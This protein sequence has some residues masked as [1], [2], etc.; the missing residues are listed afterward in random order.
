MRAVLMLATV[1]L[2]APFPAAAQAPAVLHITVDVTDADQRSVPAARL[3]LLISDNP[4][5][6]TPRRV[7]T[8]TDGTVDVRL[9]PGNYTIESDQPYAFAGKAYEWVETLDVRGAPITLALTERNA[10]VAPLTDAVIAASKP[11][12]AALGPHLPAWKDSLVG[13]WTPRQRTSGFVID[14]R[15]LIATSQRAVGDA[16]T[17][18]VQVAPTLTVEGRVLVADATRD[19]AVLWIDSAVVSAMPPAPLG[20]GQPTLSLASDQDVVALGVP[21]RSQQDHIVR[22][23]VRRT[24]THTIDVDLRLPPGTPGGP[25]LTVD[26]TLIGITSIVDDTDARRRQARAVPIADACEVVSA[27]QQTMKDTPPPSAAHR[28]M[29]PATPFPIVALQDALA[30][31]AGNLNPYRT[32]ASDFDVAFITPIMVFAS[33]QP[34]RR[35]TSAD[36]RSAG[37]DQMRIPRWSDFG[38]WGDYVA[39]VRSVLLVRVTPRLAEGL[40]TK[41]GRGAAMTQGVNLPALKRFKAALSR[42]RAFCG[43]AEVMPI[44]RFT[45]ES[46]IIERET[47]VEGLYAFDP[48]AFGPHCKTVTLQLYADKDPE[49]GDTTTVE[50]AVI[51]QMWQDFEPYRVQPS[52]R[53]GQPGN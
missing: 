53:I 47:V 16:T 35:T 14:A 41:I 29:E 46:N 13:L 12:A 7:V 6:S 30:R 9:P 31:R 2:L 49:H 45:L 5:T 38:V 42:L 28:P 52:S 15:G 50:P 33:Q 37:M 4:A 25:L 20:C 11:P 51:Q 34:D 43:D 8:G 21:L 3:A 23:S 39:D 26:G 10:V 27:A 24:T 19:V 32:S 36:T 44:H 17:V 1:V 22:G 48:G 40:W 18:D